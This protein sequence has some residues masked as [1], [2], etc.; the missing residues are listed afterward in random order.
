MYKLT[1]ETISK[2]K[3]A[4]RVCYHNCNPFEFDEVNNP[5]KK[6]KLF[7]KPKHPE[8][9]WIDVYH[10][11]KIKQSFADWVIENGLTVTRVDSTPDLPLTTLQRTLCSLDLT[12]RVFIF[13]KLDEYKPY[14][15]DKDLTFWFDLINTF[16]KDFEQFVGKVN[17]TW[18]EFNYYNDLIHSFLVEFS[19]SLDMGKYVGSKQLEI[20]KLI[21]DYLSS[22][23]LMMD[24]VTVVKNFL[25]KIEEKN[26]KELYNI[27]VNKIEKENFK[28]KTVNGKN[29]SER[30]INKPLKYMGL[31]VTDSSSNKHLY[32]EVESGDF[33][34]YAYFMVYEEPVK[35]NQTLSN[36]R[37]INK[38]CF[39][40][41][42]FDDGKGHDA[43]FVP[44]W[45]T[46][47]I[48]NN[49]VTDKAGYLVAFEKNQWNNPIIAKLD[50]L[51]AGYD[52]V[53]VL[54]AENIKGLK[55]HY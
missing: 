29:K 41:D 46:L 44:S 23:V 9:L 13:V 31:V 53:K 51:D 6:H 35:F 12:W 32:A 7:T 27:T 37:I 8:N 48:V 33:N 22:F 55:Y 52:S 11:L 26:K 50:Q 45:M 15:F 54:T 28:M 4:N 3:H 49:D 38:Y 19:W 47:E 20:Y 42:N 24:R 34:K 10:D 5:P 30:M 14:L 25:I 17:N 1:K 39:H 36:G 18:N 2:I 16:N 21:D 43:I 40:I